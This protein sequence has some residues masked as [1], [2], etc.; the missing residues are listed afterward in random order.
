MFLNIIFKHAPRWF[1]S[2]RR[3][4]QP[5]H[6]GASEGPI[7]SAPKTTLLGLPPTPLGLPT[8][9]S[10]KHLRSPLSLGE[11]PRGGL[12]LQPP[13]P[14]PSGQ[15][16]RGAATNLHTPISPQLLPENPA[17]HAAKRRAAGAPLYEKPKNKRAAEKPDPGNRGPPR[18]PRGTKAQRRRTDRHNFPTN[19][20]SV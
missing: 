12:G 7:R 18:S 4:S 19:I 16:R 1:R 5:P 17:A 11:P 13:P 8:K 15:G 6:Y 3:L 2:V 14:Q 9:T 10:T 20:T